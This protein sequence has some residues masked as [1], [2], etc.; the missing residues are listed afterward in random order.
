M[1]IAM[2]TAGCIAATVAGHVGGK[3]IHHQ[4]LNPECL[5][6]DESLWNRRETTT[7]LIMFLGAALA[8][9]TILAT[10]Y[11][12]SAEPMLIDP[13]SGQ[14]WYAIILASCAIFDIAVG[15]AQWVMAYRLRNQVDHHRF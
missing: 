4:V 15:V 2:F 10:R 14:P 6:T 12:F 1:S 13:M 11:D 3:R 7:A 5:N 9:L 8:I